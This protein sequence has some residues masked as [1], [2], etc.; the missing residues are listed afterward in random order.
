MGVTEEV[1]G[2]RDAGCGACRYENWGG[3]LLCK[4]CLVSVTYETG[5]G[6]RESERVI[7]LL[8]G[9]DNRTSSEGSTRRNVNVS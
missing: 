9:D 1:P 7:V 8:E 4:G 3:P 6:E 5:S 2:V